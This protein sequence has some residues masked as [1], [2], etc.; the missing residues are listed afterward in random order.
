MAKRSLSSLKRVRQT[1]KRAE[2]NKSRRSALK[3]QVRRFTDAA[4]TG[5]ADVA[6][7]EFLAASALLDRAAAHGVIHKNTAGRRKSRLAKQMNAL[8]P[9]AAKSAAKPASKSAAEK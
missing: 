4:A 2:R 6:S 8:K 7:K 1:A 9:G 5:K 3:S